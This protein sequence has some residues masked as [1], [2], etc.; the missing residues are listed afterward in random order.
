MMKKNSR[1]VL[2]LFPFVLVLLIDVFYTI[3]NY[4][5]II[6]PSSKTI[7]LST[8]IMYCLFSICVFITKSLNKANRI[9]YIFFFFFL[10]INQMKI[11]YTQEPIY[12]SDIYHL[13]NAKGL[14]EITNGTLMQSIKIFFIPLFSQVITFGILIFVTYKC[15]QCLVDNRKFLGLIIP[16]VLLLVM[17]FPNKVI[18]NFI[19]SNIFDNNKI[20]DFN[21]SINDQG[22][23]ALK[24]VISGMYGQFLENR[25]FEPDNYSEDQLNKFLN[26]NNSIKDEKDIKPNIILFVSESFWDIDQLKEIQ[27]DKQVASNFKQIAQT[28][29]TKFFNMLSATYGGLSA[30]VEW[31]LLV[32]ANVSFYSK[33][34]IPYLRLYKND[35]YYERNSIVKE[36]R[37]NGYVTKVMAATNKNSYNHGKV[38]DYMK[39]DSVEYFN[40]VSKEYKKGYY[41]SDEYI[42]TQLIED[43]KNNVDNAKPS[44]HFVFTMQAHMPYMLNKYN[45][46]DIK[47]KNSNLDEKSN[48]VLLS[49]A[50]GIYDADQQLKRLYEF[51]LTYKKPTILVFLGDHLPYLSTS[52]GENIIE[53]LEFFNTK[54]E[55]MNLYRKYNTQSLVVSNYDI[56]YDSLEYLGTDLLMPYVLEKA[57][58]N[59]SSYYKYLNNSISILPTFNRFIIVDKLGNIKYTNAISKDLLETYNLRKNLQYKLFFK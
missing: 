39:F 15:S 50:Q 27:F 8:V 18:N 45:S 59:L 12:I 43:L 6:I 44:F 37:D 3:Y 33:A 9:I 4:N 51:L 25:V 17:F 35:S 21:Y 58:I 57:N 19:L 38:Y 10:I 20:E 49:Y 26:E 46:Y 22:Y 5:R 28:N 16:V 53:Q 36:L 56:E 54:D 47:I 31:E 23:Y 2:L 24:G 40:N 52:S 29:N 42:T 32:G 13:F 34:Y 41:V 7:L 14:V 55:K 30:N 11:F 1:K 48:N